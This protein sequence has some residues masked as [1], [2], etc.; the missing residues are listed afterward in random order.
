MG[1]LLPK[2]L[3]TAGAQDAPLLR[4]PELLAPAG[5]WECARAAIEN[6]ADAVYFGLEQFNAR[7]RAHNFSTAELP[8]I[9]ARLHER[10][11]RGYVT[12]NTLVFANE[13]PEAE[14]F[15]R[16]IIAAG[17]DAAIVQDVGACRLIRQLSPDFPIHAST[18]MSVTSEAGVRFAHELG[19]SLVVLAR[20]CSLAEISAIREK[21]ATDGLELPLEIFVHGALCVAYSGQCLTSE[22][23]GGR[24]A[25]RGECAQACR[26]PYELISDGELVELGER[27]YLLSP[28]DLAG[29]SALPQVVRA[30]VASLKIEGR[31]KTP[32]YVSAV[33]GVYRRALDKAWEELAPDDEKSPIAPVSKKNDST[34]LSPD[35]QRY[36]L[37]MTFSRGFHTGW[38][39]GIDNRQLV[40]A[41][42]GKNRGVRVGSVMAASPQGLLVDL[43]GPVKPGDGVVVDQG[44]PD[45]P[46]AG[47]NVNAVEP[48][49]KL[50]LLRLHGDA[51]RRVRVEEGAIVWKTADPALDRELRQS[52]EVEQ[53]RYKR[54]LTV[55][56]EGA[57]GQPLLLT[58]A[59]EEGFE[60]VAES[61]Q[62]LD[63]AQ[64]KP[65]DEAVL[66]KQLGRL[67][68]TPFRLAR[69]DNRLPAG[70]MLPLS[71][72]NACRRLAVERLQE[73]RRTGRRWTLIEP[74]PGQSALSAATADIKPLP[75]QETAELIP[76][77]RSM[78]Q[79]E[80]A[81]EHAG[82]D[83][84]VELED[85]KR[86]PQ[87]VERVRA[88]GGEHT[89]W[90]APPRIFKSGEDW[91]IKQ[92]LKCGADGFL[93]RNHEHLRALQGQRL[94]GDFS[95]NVAN[96][97]SAQWFI[98]RWGLERL[99]CSYDLNASQLAS[100]LESAP[101]AWF[102]VT[103]HQHMPMFH[104]EHCV[105]CAFLS[106]GKDFR[107]CGRPCDSHAVSLRDRTGA[108][109]PLK[110]DAG[111]RNTLFNARAQT[112]A[113]FAQD[114]L[115][116]GVRHYRIEFLNESP[117]EVRDALRRY[118]A[119]LRGEI[120][121]TQLWHELKLVN[122]LGV[123]R[124]TLRG[125]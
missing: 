122:Q 85:P 69:L 103:L 9:M 43:E 20:E 123:T 48:Q 117:Q 74:A 4:K 57:A 82:G 52:F 3:G 26:L 16:K 59:D 22:A 18:Q 107:D 7:M 11:V 95:L 73:K 118:A 17:V 114:L 50:T 2:R 76:L 120:S 75:V 88:A 105:F 64:N 6:G 119:L 112:G 53:P 13:M 65:L 38:L 49:G 66:R 51:L 30:G 72:L 27:R 113:E 62:P 67:G 70:L 84:Y 97:L 34:E 56:V 32:E 89:V 111:C 55:T 87:A 35:Q 14:A 5:D 45:L 23:L 29:L 31:L 125:T 124:G 98:E 104:M 102:E 21:C 106:E 94:R 28:Q 110:A 108:E 81:L 71:L 79:M 101:P 92:L 61:E 115:G 109:H 8:D 25:N 54:P 19:C 78:E 63:P 99:T 1:K 68:D 91:I 116:L 121:G 39:E 83:I 100:L 33:T 42:R 93:A 86:Y 36:R 37:D 10:G 44:R 58:L 96:A 15:L 60:A 77:V 12:F 24:S 80:A 46:E 41:R 40:H 47:G 90:V